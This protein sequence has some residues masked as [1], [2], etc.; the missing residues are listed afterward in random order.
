MKVVHKQ[1]AAVGPAAD[2]EPAEHLRFVTDADLP[3]LNPVV[4]DGSQIL[5]QRAE[6]HAAV[7]GEE[8]GGLAAF[9]VAFHV[10]QLHFEAV[11]GDLFPADGH[12]VLFLLAG[13]LLGAQVHLRRL[14]QYTAQRL[15][16]RGVFH[17]VILATADSQF[18]AVCGIYNHRVANLNFKTGRV[19]IIGLAAVFEFNAYYFGHSDSPV[20]DS[21]E[22]GGTDDSSAPA[23]SRLK[24]CF[25]LTLTFR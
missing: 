23:A 2:A 18:H 25:G 10:D 15:D 1:V 22:C 21:P 6:I 24:M 12:G 11:L 14:A 5:Y 17:G 20:S 16:D 13:K 9:K 8:K 4:Q 3:Q 7:G 19:K